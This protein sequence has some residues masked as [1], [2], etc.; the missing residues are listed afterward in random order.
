MRSGM[1]SQTIRPLCWAGLLAL[2]LVLSAGCATL[3]PDADPLVVRAEQM[4]RAVFHLCDGF[5]RWERLYNRD[6]EI[7]RIADTIRIK[8]PPIFRAVRAATKAY[9]AERNQ[10]GREQ[11]VAWLA[12]LE[13]IEIEV[14]SAMPGG[15]K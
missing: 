13:S 4:T 5:L 14:R 15:E 12:A 10:Q 9:K 11:L 6:A 1:R 7:K 2:V 8:A 3:R